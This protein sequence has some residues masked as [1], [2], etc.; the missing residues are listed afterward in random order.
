MSWDGGRSLPHLTA[1]QCSHHQKSTTVKARRKRKE[2]EQQ[3]EQVEIEAAWC[4][5]FDAPNHA[6][7][8]FSGGKKYLRGNDR[9]A[10]VYVEKVD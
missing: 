9:N 6:K 8:F 4:I 10:T 2:I 1:T 5:F 3:K 7:C